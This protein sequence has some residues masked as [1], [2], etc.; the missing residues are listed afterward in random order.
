MSE[1]YADDLHVG[2][3]FDLG[4]YRITHDDITEFASRWDPQFFHTDPQRAQLDGHFGGLIASG[5]QT[6]AIYQRLWVLSRDRPWH[7]IA[8]AGIDQ[9]RLHRPVR[10][11]DTLAGRCTISRIDHEDERRRALVVTEGELTNQQDKSVLTQTMSVYMRTREAGSR[12][13]TA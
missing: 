11:D 1:L 7:V 9:L 5:I 13:R 8:G 6:M 12:E 2:D 10:A 4:S 3:V